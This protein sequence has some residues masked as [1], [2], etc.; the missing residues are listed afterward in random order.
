ML[1]SGKHDQRFFDEIFA[2]A[3]RDGWWKG[4]IVNRRKSGEIY[5]VEQTICAVRNDTGSV[6]R[7]IAIMD[8]ITERKSTEERMRYLAQHDFLTGLA[9]RAVLGD[10]IERAILRVHRNRR[11]VA[12]LLLDLD[13]FKEINDTHGH[14]VGDCLLKQV[15]GRLLHVIRQTDTVSRLGGDE[16]VIVLPDLRARVDA[17]RI[18]QKVVEELSPPFELESVR[19]EVGVS[20]GIALYPDDATDGDTLCRAADAAMY[21]W[22]QARKASNAQFAS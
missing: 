19:V 18:A 1:G 17:E 15:A 5:V 4:E 12:V 22:K 21:R 8:D 10:R 14:A 3:D 20:I 13:D 16:F 7:Y 2:A 9:N 11:K 6:R